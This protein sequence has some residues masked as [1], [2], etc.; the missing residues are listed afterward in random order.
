MGQRLT[1][2]V[3]SN[4]RAFSSAQAA[5]NVHALPGGAP[6]SGAQ[7]SQSLPG[8]PQAENSAQHHDFLAAHIQRKLNEGTGRIL[9]R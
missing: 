1:T 4:G 8:N 2:D 7:A 6:A 5:V 3:G 9:P